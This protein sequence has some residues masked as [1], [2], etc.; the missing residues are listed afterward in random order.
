M[1]IKLINNNNVKSQNM[2]LDGLFMAILID[3]M[4][5]NTKQ[6]EQEL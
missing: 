2:T 5:A 1:Q 3:N 6:I 4:K